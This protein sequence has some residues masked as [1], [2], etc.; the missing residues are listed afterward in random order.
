MSSLL[1]V[2]PIAFLVFQVQ[3]DLSLTVS[4]FCSAPSSVAA[5]A[6]QTNI[7]QINMAKKKFSKCCASVVINSKSSQNHVGNL[8]AW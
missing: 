4:V 5:F 7:K 1:R 8:V 3:S 6:L 2:L